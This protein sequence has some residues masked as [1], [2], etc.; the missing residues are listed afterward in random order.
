MTRKQGSKESEGRLGQAD[1]FLEEA[2]NLCLR[3]DHLLK[4]AGDSKGSVLASR[5]SI[6]DSAK[7]LCL[8][9]GTDPPR[10]HYFDQEATQNALENLPP[11]AAPVRNFL[12]VFLYANLWFPTD[13]TCQY[14]FRYERAKDELKNLITNED[15]GVALRHAWYCYYTV[16]ELRQFLKR[17]EQDEEE[18][19]F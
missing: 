8:M 6:E 11:K 2:R 17:Q 1:A 10:K 15:A 9:L 19:S 16:D 18:I 3:S 13:M 4:R 7:A 12:R 14:P 5:Q